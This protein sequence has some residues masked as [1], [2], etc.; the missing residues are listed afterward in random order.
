MTFGYEMAIKTP[1]DKVLAGC[2]P[3]VMKRMEWENRNKRLV[4]YA[5]AHPKWTHEA[6]AGVF[7][8][9]RSR[10]TRILKRARENG[11]L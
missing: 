2:Y 3:S 8:I 7:H 11:E 10:V 5:K 9:D 1:L 6:I 4:E